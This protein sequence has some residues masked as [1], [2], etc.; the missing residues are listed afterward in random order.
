MTYNGG[1][2]PPAG[3][4]PD[5]GGAGLRWWDGT[6]WTDH[7]AP[8][9]QPQPY[10]YMAASTDPEHAVRQER[11]VAR[12]ARSVIVVYALSVL[13]GG[14]LALRI[15]AAVPEMMAEGLRQAEAGVPP[16]MQ[17]MPFGTELAMQQLFNL[18]GLASMIMLLVWVHRA[19]KAGAALGIPARR[20]PGWAVGSWFIPI[21]NLWLPLQ[22]LLD[23][24]PPEH[25]SRPGSSFCGSRP[26]PV[27]W[28]APS[29]SSE[30]PSATTPP[31]W[32]LWAM[33]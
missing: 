17:T 19:A 4:F 12:L 29:A 1:N 26:S 30:A 32:G 33:S 14:Y 23:L 28:W 7:A 27:T 13:A 3:W 2:M 25:P 24:L 9:P 8:L 10:P 6:R 22:S 5:P 11:D 18:V 21:A 31:C 16:D 20:S 15:L